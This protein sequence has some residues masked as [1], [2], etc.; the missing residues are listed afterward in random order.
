MKVFV[1]GDTHR[2]ERDDFSK[3][4]SMAFPEGESLTKDDLVIIC[5]DMGLTWP[6]WPKQQRQIRYW[7]K[8]LYSKPDN[9]ICRWQS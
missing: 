1:T 9:I 3:L 5:G 4:G 8:W 2:G 6:N 7:M